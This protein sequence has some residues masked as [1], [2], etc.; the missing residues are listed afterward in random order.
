MKDV[1]KEVKTVFEQQTKWLVGKNSCKDYFMRLSDKD[2]KY[3]QDQIGSRHSLHQIRSS[4]TILLEE[5]TTDGGDHGL[6]VYK[7][8]PDMD[9]DSR[10]LY[11]SLP[12][13]KKKIQH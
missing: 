12:M 13:T 11:L 4:F 9:S 6:M 2:R 7:I 10:L 3:V 5:T 1:E 8:L